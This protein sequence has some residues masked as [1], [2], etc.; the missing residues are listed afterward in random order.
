MA[1]YNRTVKD[2]SLNGMNNPQQVARVN[3]FLV[4]FLFIALFPV[5]LSM[6]AQA[7]GLE[8]KIAVLPFKIESA[9]PAGGM[10]KNLQVL[11]SQDM[12]K[13]GFQV[14]SPELTNSILGD[15]FSYSD[16]EKEIIPFAKANGAEWVIIGEMIEREGNIRLNVKVLNPVSAKTPFSVMMIE[17]NRKNLPEALTKIAESLSI[18]IQKNVL[19]SDIK[20]EGNKRVSDDAILNIIESKK[21]EKFD[22]EKLDRDL[23]TIYKMGLFDDVNVETSDGP[24]GKIIT[25]NLVEKPI[26][27]RIGFK[28]NK[29]KKDDKLKEEIGIKIYAVLNRSEVRQSINRLLEFYRESGYYNVK[30][31]DQIKEL[32]NNEVTLTYVIDEGEKVYIKDIEFRGN[33]VFDSDDLR[34]LMLTKEKN[35]LSWF[36][37]SGVLDKK[38]LE[39]DMQRITAYYDNHGYIKARVGEP[40]ITYDEKKKG[41]K[42]VITI[43]EGERYIVNEVS[44]EGDLLIPAD[45]LKKIV[46]I[47]KGEPFSR[48]NVYT[49]MENIKD[50]YSDM[51]YAYAD[52]TPYTSE[53]EG[54]DLINIRLKIE[55][56]KRVRIE[57]INIYGNEITKDKVLRRELTLSEGEYFSRIRLKQSEANLDR[58]EIFEDHEVKTRKGSSDDQMIID[59]DGK[60]KLQRSISFSAG[61]G[62]YEKFAVMLQFADNNMLGRGQN[63][64]IEAMMGAATTRFNATFTDPWL[65]DKPVRGSITAY[66]WDMDYDEYTRKRLGG[67]LG[68]AFL[69]G[70]DNFTRGTVQYTYDRSEVTDIYPGAS[71]LIKDMAGENLTSSMTVGIERNSKDRWWDTTRGSL[72]A[73]T[74]EYAGG[75]FGGDVAFN[76]YQLNSTWYLPVFK[77]TVLVASAQLGYIHGRADGK[78]PLYEK[79]R[80]GGIDTIRGYEWGTISPLD[81]GTWDELGGDMMWLYKLEYRV[82]L[83]KG[84][85]GITGLVFFDAGNAFLKG[86]SWKSGAGSS[87]GFGVRWYSP[88]G[89]LRLEYGH[90]LNK[91]PNDTDSGK[92]EFKIGGSF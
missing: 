49:E 76:K 71:A 43:I 80:L 25:F 42:L 3:I 40:K 50:I 1:D 37:D 21:G 30:I 75:F 44:F 12:A 53:V 15:N 60:E 36:T 67:N 62:G 90:K 10:S 79:F 55:K 82:P 91:R 31:K 11:F 51:G 72:N 8:K 84:E 26:I 48:Q 92:F 13:I 83:A 52:V 39:F 70:L 66:D 81:P 33:K 20:I 41:L 57:R 64:Q 27:I 73:F 54:S 32:P 59:I 78:L 4:F 19:I 77:K 58:L 35:W 46:N 22:Q 38:K 85:K 2:K 69:L 9:E 47:K 56:N 74:F 7:Y 45:T 61:Y 6:P 17:N 5:V 18:Q 65:F 63:F 34:D 28:G 16:P 87:V 29:Q 23:R 24:G 86:D 68:L 89:P 14:L 88:M